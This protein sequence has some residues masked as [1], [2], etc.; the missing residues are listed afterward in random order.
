M[1]LKSGLEVSGKLKF[2]PG[3]IPAPLKACINTWNAS[4]ASQAHAE[5][6]ASSILTNVD[7]GEAALTANWSGFAMLLTLKPSPLESVFVNNPQLLASCGIGLT[8]KKVEEVIDGDEAEFFSG[9]M[10]LEVQPLPT[11]IRFSPATVV[12][13]DHSYHAEAVLGENYLRYDIRK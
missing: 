8:V 1:L 9:K 6:S 4:F 10:K 2:S 7:V 12:F 13:G 5:P 3:N 11:K